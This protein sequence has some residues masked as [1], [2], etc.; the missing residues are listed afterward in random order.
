MLTQWG[1][2]LVIKLRERDLEFATCS[3]ISVLTQW[4]ATLVIK[5]QLR[6]RERERERDVFQ[7]SIAHRSTQDS[8]FDIRRVCVKARGKPAARRRSPAPPGGCECREWECPPE[9]AESR[10]ASRLPRA[11]SKV[12]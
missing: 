5:V 7:R 1:A 2:T 10:V 4:G 9:R 3:I 11:L 12:D 8:R 6:E